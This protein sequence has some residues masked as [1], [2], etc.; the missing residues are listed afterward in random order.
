M[1]QG[2]VNGGGQLGDLG[3]GWRSEFR[4]EIWVQGRDVG[5]P[6]CLITASDMPEVLIKE[7]GGIDKRVWTGVLTGWW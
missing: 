4:V 5:Q 3:P 7:A 1:T 6:R 2:D